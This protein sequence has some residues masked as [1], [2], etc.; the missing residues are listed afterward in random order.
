LDESENRRRIGGYTMR[1]T[2]STNHPDQ[3]TFRNGL[4]V[5][6]GFSPSSHNGLGRRAGGRHELASNYWITRSTRVDTVRDALS[7]AAGRGEP[8]ESLE[9]TTRAMSPGYPMRPSGEPPIISFSNSLP[10]IR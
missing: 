8:R 1:V 9:A 3:Q 4:E 2:G 7:K 5:C 10:I 6:N